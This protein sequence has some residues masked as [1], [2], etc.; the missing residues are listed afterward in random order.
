MVSYD[1]RSPK[2]NNYY[3]TNFNSITKSNIK[4]HKYFFEIS[5]PNKQLNSAVD[6]ND[7]KSAFD[8]SIDSHSYKSGFCS[9]NLSNQNSSNNLSKMSSH[10]SKLSFSNLYY[11]V[12]L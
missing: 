3:R 10:N 5:I 2:P 4:I 6:A 9:T 8:F 11:R 1:N 7:S 12:F